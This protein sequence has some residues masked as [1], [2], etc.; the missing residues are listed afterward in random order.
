MTSS[1]DSNLRC[2]VGQLDAARAASTEVSHRAATGPKCTKPL[3]GV[4]RAGGAIHATAAISS[5]RKSSPGRGTRSLYQR[6]EAS[7]LAARR[8]NSDHGRL[9]AR[10]I[11]NAVPF[12]WRPTPRAAGERAHGGERQPPPT[13]SW[14]ASSTRLC[15][16]SYPPHSSS[17]RALVPRHPGLLVSQRRCCSHRTRTIVSASSR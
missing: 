2:L 9:A 7:A 4:G 14:R 16:P 3:A 12:E 15:L 11:A 5:A 1:R 6:T 10:A 17:A 8:T 13:D